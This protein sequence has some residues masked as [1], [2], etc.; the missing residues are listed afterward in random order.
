[1]PSTTT[2]L[3]AATAIAAL[4][5]VTGARAE[6]YRLGP[7]DQLVIKVFLFRP[8][9]AESVAV[10]ALNG[11]FTVAAD[12][13]L[14]LPV[15]GSM[16]ASGQTPSEMADAIGAA[17]KAKIGLPQQP[18]ASVQ[19]AKYRP[20]FILGSVQKA[21]DYPFRPGMTVLQAVSVAGGVNRAS[22][23]DRAGYEREAL[24]GRGEVRALSAERLGLAVRQARL[25]AE[26]DGK[27][28]VQF[29]DWVLRRASDP[30]VSQAMR[31]QS[32]LLDAR[33]NSV[34][35]QVKA[36]QDAKE[37]LRQE[38]QSLD[39]KGKSL[40]HQID[41][42][43][44]ELANVTDLV[45][46]GLT[47]S[48]RQLADEQ[49]VAAFES[50]RLD[51][52]L[53]TLRAQQD[54]SRADRDIL[55][56]RAK[57]R[58]DALTDAAEVRSRLDAIEERLT[59]AAGLVSNAE[60]NAPEV[61]REGEI[62]PIYTLT[63][64]V[65]GAST[66]SRV[67]ETDAVRPGDVVRVTLPKNPDET[68]RGA[69][70]DYRTRSYAPAGPMSL[71]GTPSVQPPQATASPQAQPQAAAAAAPTGPTQPARVADMPAQPSPAAVR[72]RQPGAIDAT[73]ASRVVVPDD[74]AHPARR[75]DH[76]SRTQRQQPASTVAD[77]EDQSPTQP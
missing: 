74:K 39:T 1:M 27:P 60:Q 43:R 32:L 23:I 2:K 59:T 25:S 17:L 58:T 47:I 10:P 77:G 65:D 56:L 72:P 3:L 4:A 14:S 71:N 5:W 37:I 30:D 15:L 62:V 70:E 54:L 40:D 42:A 68:R 29:P 35:E 55:D 66:T 57:Y 50:S 52:Q 11:D 38:L 19:V 34:D 67:A 64:I 45:Q 51:T 76:S 53:T 75:K 24:S 69:P 8:G 46:K 26:V 31:E 48:P 28:Q 20:F 61:A 16:P 18:E 21:G 12:G 44:K 63:R 33:R 13:T 7:E 22:D 49:S 6:P 9:T 73:S 41:I 36:V